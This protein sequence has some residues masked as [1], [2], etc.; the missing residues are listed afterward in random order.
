MCVNLDCCDEERHL[1]V[2]FNELPQVGGASIDVFL[3]PPPLESTAAFQIIKLGSIH[4][5]GHRE[6]ETDDYVNHSHTTRSIFIDHV[7]RKFHIP[8]TD[9]ENGLEEIRSRLQLV[10]RTPQNPLG[11]PFSFSGIIS[12]DTIIFRKK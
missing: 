3:L 6:E 8:W 7:L 1:R 5:F 9:S 10:I 11:I 12:V 2:T 4:I